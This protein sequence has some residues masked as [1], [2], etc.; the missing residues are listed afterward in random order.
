MA[1]P[2]TESVQRADAVDWHPAAGAEIAAEWTRRQLRMGQKTHPDLQAH[3]L[4]A[5]RDMTWSHSVVAG[6]ADVEG[7]HTRSGRASADGGRKSGVVGDNIRRA[8]SP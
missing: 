6:E 7:R 1:Q 3:Q 2:P 4:A 5:V 8:E